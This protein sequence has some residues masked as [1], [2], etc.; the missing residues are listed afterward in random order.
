DF[1]AAAMEKKLKNAFAGLP[2][3]PVLPEPKIEPHPAQ[4]GYYL[5]NKEDVNQ[6]NVRMVAPGTDRHN[7]DYFA[8]EVFNEVMGGGFSS[9]LVQDI[10]TAKGLAYSVGGGIGTA[11]DHPGITRFV[12]GTKSERTIESIE[13]LYQD[14]DD[15]KSHPIT[16]DEI[17]RAKDSILNSFIFNFDTPDKVLRERMAYQFYGYPLNFLEQYRAG[18]EKATVA[19]VNRVAAKYLHKDQLAVL[20][21]GN[22]K[23]FDKP[24]SALG[25]VSNVDI[26]IPPPPGETPAAGASASGSVPAPA[27]IASNPEGKALAAKVV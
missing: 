20:V 14:V 8:I 27:P 4:P 19:D 7:P 12:L 22:P 2:K 25:P 26:T 10:R 9:R 15:L 16:G 24:I 5:V 1:D 3:G 11:F 23:E 21:V 18:I 6:S 17:K 13:A